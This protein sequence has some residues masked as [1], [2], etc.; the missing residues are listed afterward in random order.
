MADSPMRP[1]K[2]QWTTALRSRM[3]SGEDAI[4]MSTDAD[5]VWAALALGAVSSVGLLA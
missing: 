2:V 1:T 3:L 5:Q 4:R